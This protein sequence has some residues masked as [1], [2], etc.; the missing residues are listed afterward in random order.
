M[1]EIFVRIIKM[2][3][4]VS[5]WCWKNGAKT[6]IQYKV[7]TEMKFLNIREISVTHNKMKKNEV[8]QPVYLAP[9]WLSYYLVLL[10]RENGY[11]EKLTEEIVIHRYANF[12]IVSS[13]E[14]VNLDSEHLLTDEIIS[15]LPTFANMY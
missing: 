9:T 8:S 2:L 13:L 6:F 15:L 10:F 1:F 3:H 5:R 14:T 4:N 11:L 7:G 12:Q